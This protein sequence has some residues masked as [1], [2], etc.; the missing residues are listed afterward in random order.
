MVFTRGRAETLNSFTLNWWLP[1]LKII[2]Y[3]HPYFLRVYHFNLLKKC[4]HN[5]GITADWEN[6]ITCHLSGLVNTLVMSVVC[7]KKRSLKIRVF[8][9]GELPHPFTSWKWES[10]HEP[11]LCSS[12]TRKNPP[13]IVSPNQIFIPPPVRFIPPLDNNFHIRTL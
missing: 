12:P 6:S 7:L 13:A 8:P 10:P 11:R 2:L 5:W 9:A 4:R 3:Y 1:T